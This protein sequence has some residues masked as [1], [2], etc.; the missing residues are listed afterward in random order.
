MAN[1]STPVEKRRA[2]Y[3]VVS[4]ILLVFAVTLF[5]L[6]V[7]F[8]GQLNDLLGNRA[9]YVVLFPLGFSAAAFLFGAMNS[10]ARYSGKHLNGVLQLG[11]P[12]IAAG[13]VI[14]GGFNL[15]ENTSFSLSLRP[16]FGDSTTL[17]T[18][19]PLVQKP[20][21]E[22]LI[23][24][25]WEPIKFADDLFELKNIPG[26]YKNKVVQCRLK[27][28]YWMTPDATINL[29][30]KMQ[31]IRLQPDASLS[32]VIGVVLES[33]FSPISNAVIIMDDKVT[34]SD[35]TGSFVFN[36]PF[37]QQQL[38]KDVL[39]KKEGFES[40]KVTIMAGDK[41]EIQLEKL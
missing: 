8:H 27:C 4:I 12:V 32:K 10:Y 13:A 25:K 17:N 11:G 21:L 1:T 41:A 29:K 16:V 26:E 3:L 22:V 38:K 20:V 28:P 18:N 19:Y 30:E 23:G 7:A 14:F 39:I 15:P 36:I 31:I 34:E 9:F 40:K 24:S 33:S 35:S 37:V 2:L 5:A 6:L